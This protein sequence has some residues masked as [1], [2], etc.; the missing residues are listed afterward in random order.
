MNANSILYNG[1]LIESNAIII[2]F[3]KSYAPLLGN[4]KPLNIKTI[5]EFRSINNLDNFKSLKPDGILHLAGLYLVM[6]KILIVYIMN[7]IYI[8]I[9][10]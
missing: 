2:K 3:K 4:S 9:I 8:S 6:F 7:M 1:Q 10:N 5:Q